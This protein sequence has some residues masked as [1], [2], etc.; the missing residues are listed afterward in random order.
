MKKSLLFLFLVICVVILGLSIWGAVES[1]KTSN[2]GVGAGATLG[3]TSSVLAGYQCI[4]ELARMNRV[5]PTV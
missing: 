2:F 4:K 5:S 1:Y 3:L